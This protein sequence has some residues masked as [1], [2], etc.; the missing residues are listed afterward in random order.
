MD[1]VFVTD[2]NQL[3]GMLA[4][5][6]SVIQNCRRDRGLRFSI[7]SDADSHADVLHHTNH[8]FGQANVNVRVVA[9]H[10][11]AFLQENIRVNRGGRLSNLMNY[12][13]FYLH[14]VL[15]DLDKI[16]YLDADVIVQGDIVELWS[17]AKLDQHIIACIPSAVGSYDYM[18]SFYRDAASLAHIDHD[19]R[20]FNAGVYVTRLQGWEEQRILSQLEHWMVLHK[21]D[22]KGFFELGTQPLLNLVF[23]QDYEHLPPEWNVT[24]LG[25]QGPATLAKTTL[26]AAKILHWKGSHKPWLP[27]GYF[28]ELWN[29]YD[30]LGVNRSNA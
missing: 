30:L 22:P 3:V 9:F 12:T 26:E 24:G 2:R 16:I 27:N 6:N 14:Q 8:L 29:P 10:P 5:M 13:R 21:N 18:G 20:F 4:A 17:R 28:K 11:P 25:D 7:V 1:I 23:Y 19:E 15:P